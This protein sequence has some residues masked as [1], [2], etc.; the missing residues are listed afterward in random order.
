MPLEHTRAKR[1]ILLAGVLA[2][3]LRLLFGLVYWVDKP[4]THDEREYL[5][6]AH[7]LSEGRGFT[8]GPDHQSGTAQ[9]FGRAPL[10]PM[11]LAAIGATDAGPHGAP[12][13]VK[14][15]QAVLGA[16]FVMLLGAVALRC[17]GPRAGVAASL[18]AGVYPP[19]VWYP[20]YVLSETLFSVLAFSAAFALQTAVDRSA[21]SG[22]AQ[23]LM[24]TF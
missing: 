19:L 9:Q 24:T 17:A 5:A 1:L 16:L 21:A 4:L 11:F 2:L 13:R 22:Q 23:E 7:S 6:L 3:V 18:V 10:Y 12:G 20:A 8:Y 14:V 15:A